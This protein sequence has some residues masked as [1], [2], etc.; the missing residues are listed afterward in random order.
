MFCLK[1]IPFVWI[2]LIAFPLCYLTDFFVPCNFYKFVVDLETY[3]DAML[4]QTHIYIYRINLFIFQILHRS[5]GIPHQNVSC[6]NY[7]LL[8]NM[9]WRVLSHAVHVGLP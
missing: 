5:W 9:S 7:F 6:A 3:S 2:L 1:E 8:K 4:C